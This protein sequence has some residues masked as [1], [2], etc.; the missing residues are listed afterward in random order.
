MKR[1]SLR[2]VRPKQRVELEKRRVLKAQLM[3]EFGLCQTCGT[4][5]DWRGL[6]LSHIVALSRGGKTSRENVELL[7]YPCH[8]LVEKKFVLGA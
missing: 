2:K 1:V 5:G 4:T 6:S 7:C 3:E 8:E